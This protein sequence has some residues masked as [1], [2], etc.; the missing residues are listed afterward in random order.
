MDQDTTPAAPAAPPSAPT[1]DSPRRASTWGK[2]QV[3]PKVEPKAPAAKP[4]RAAPRRPHPCAN[5]HPR[6]HPHLSQCLSARQQRNRPS[7][8][9]GRLVSPHRSLRRRRRTSRIHPRA[10]ARHASRAPALPGAGE[11][12]VA[13]VAAADRAPR[14]RPPREPKRI[15]TRRPT[16]RPRRGSSHGR[17]R[18][19]ASSNRRPP[20]TETETGDAENETTDRNTPDAAEG[21]SSPT[22]PK[23][24]R[25]RRGGRGRGG[26][27]PTT[28]DADDADGLAGETA[29][30]QRDD[31]TPDVDATG[32]GQRRRRSAPEWRP[33]RRRDHAAEAVEAKDDRGAGR[34]GWPHAGHPKHTQSHR[35]RRPSSSRPDRAATADHRQAHG[36]HGAR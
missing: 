23:K 27:K 3:K 4:P 2:V 28:V 31:A 13:A 36:D 22:G 17:A 1:E 34:R 8:P 14:A 20:P 12:V 15:G 35:S 19:R 7:G 11:A 21:E 18:S 10:T 33:E 16:A 32:N 24:R 26:K 29:A 9:S 25:R 6:R 30:T 5:P